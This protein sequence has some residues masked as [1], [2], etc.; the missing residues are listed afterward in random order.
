[1]KKK[2]AMLA[3]LVMAVIASAYSVSGT[4]AKYTTTSTGTDS[5]IV[6]KWGI[7][8]TTNVDVFKASYSEGEPSYVDVVSGDSTDVVAPGTKGS[9]NY[10]L[11]GTPEVNYTINVDLTGSEDNTGRI[12]WSLDGSEVGNLTQLQTAINTLYNGKVFAAG[13]ASNNNHEIGWEWKF[14]EAEK[15]DDDTTLGNAEIPATVTLKVTVTATQ[16]EAEP[17]ADSIN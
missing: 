1:M 3:V 11:S 12:V 5:A 10:Q 14:E 13:T 8:A 7:N 15:D 2:I 9:F 17:N 16:S 4:Y 6:A